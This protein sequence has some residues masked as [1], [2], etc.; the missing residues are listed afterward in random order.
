[1]SLAPGISA[2]VV[3]IVGGDHVSVDLA[4]R[5]RYGCGFGDLFCAVPDAVVF[6]ASTGEVSELMRGAHVCGV[7][8]AHRS[9]ANSPT[10]AVYL[11]T[12]GIVLS[13]ERMN[14]IIDVALD[15]GI[16]RIQPYVTAAQFRSAT[17]LSRPDP[18]EMPAAALNDQLVSEGQILGLEVVLPTG[19]I[20]RSGGGLLARDLAQQDAATLLAGRDGTLAVITELTVALDP[21][22][23]YPHVAVA[24]FP[25]V[26]AA[27]A[28]ARMVMLSEPTPPRLTFL[29]PPALRDV[30]NRSRLGLRRDA[31][32]V[33]VFAGAHRSGE[34]RDLLRRVGRICTDAGATGARVAEDPTWC[35]TLL[36]TL[37]QASVDKRSDLPLPPAAGPLEAPATRDRVASE[38]WF[39]E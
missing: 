39:A 37:A 21:S 30:E 27:C 8:I 22:R 35:A 6:P 19:E 14:R 32:A 15:D 10:G 3:D 33:L 17:G 24:S 2:A 13:L 4:L 11:G 20:V 38:A 36:R 26:S 7:P 34:C 28:A 5:R 9:A 16:A 23:A 29:D 1:M 25:S 12:G 31:A 18:P